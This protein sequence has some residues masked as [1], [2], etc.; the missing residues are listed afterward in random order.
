MK[1]YLFSILLVLSPLSTIHNSE[2]ERTDQGAIENA[3]TV[4]TIFDTELDASA[5]S[6]C[7][8]E[9]PLES[10]SVVK[11]FFMRHFGPSYV[12]ARVAL[13]RWLSAVDSYL[14]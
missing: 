5:E 6:A 9:K 4:D 8:S 1:K 10:P 11:L 13:Y 3:D 14:K 2:P 12:A 7:D